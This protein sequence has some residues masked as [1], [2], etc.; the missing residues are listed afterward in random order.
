MKQH[1]LEALADAVLDGTA[2]A[3]ERERLEALV[4]DDPDAREAW[5][6]VR[7]AYESLAD[8]G[9]ENPPPGLRDSIER[10]VAREGERRIATEPLPGLA[11]WIR[12]LGTPRLS[13]RPSFRVAFAFAAG[14]AVGVLGLGAFLGGSRGL[15]S[16]TSATLAPAPA[17]APVTVAIDG[18]RLDVIV[19][20]NSGVAEVH[21]VADASAPAEVALEWDPARARIDSIRWPE[22]PANDAALVSGHLSLAIANTASS[23]IRFIP[24]EDAR[25]RI[26]VRSGE[27]SAEHVFTLPH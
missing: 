8:A 11:N 21:L 19:T 27:R 1:E 2:S 26:T 5:E 9:L 15:G 25:L 13:P 3:A 14:L 22:G 7:S 4:R 16:N 24:S 18:A 17:V 12:S 10:A 6:S 23:T 20:K